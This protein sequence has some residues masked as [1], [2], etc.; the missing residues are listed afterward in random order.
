MVDVRPF[1]RRDREQL[2]RLANAHIATALPGGS[3][4]AATLLNQLEHP[5]GE[6]IIGPWV[7]DLATFVAVERDRVV[8]AAH[9]RRYGDDNRVSTSYRNAGEIVWLLCWPDH[10][11]AGRAV[12]DRALAQLA[13]WKVTVQYGDGTLPAPGVYGVADSWPHVHRLYGEAGF[14]PSG[15]H[16]EV[17]FAGSLDGIG[18]PGPPPVPGL[19]VRREV[20]TLGVAFNGVLEGDVV[21][22]FEVDADLTHGGT[23]V[24][25]AGWAD[26]CNHSVREDRRGQGI[27][28][29]LVQTAASWLRLG[30]TTRLL[31]YAWEDASIEATT[32]YYRRYGLVPIT[33][34]TRGWQRPAPQ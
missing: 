31:S 15:G 19:S 27:G 17:V 22:T 26:E 1:A 12:R 20:G 8:A 13:A 14:D 21:G 10:L 33:R 7:V 23:N 11:D 24:A 4:P 18:E 3:V 29:W 34:N 5:I 9:L 32:R 2:T 28:T 30:G 16:V 6:Y 25:M